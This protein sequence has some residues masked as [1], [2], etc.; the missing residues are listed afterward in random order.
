MIIVRGKL[1]TITKLGFFF[2]NFRSILGQNFIGHIIKQVDERSEEANEE[3][4]VLSI[5][6]IVPL[7]EQRPD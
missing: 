2:W 1:V 4:P 6:T 5:S 3:D 7:N